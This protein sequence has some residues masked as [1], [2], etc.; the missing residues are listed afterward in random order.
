MSGFRRYKGYAR[1][2]PIAK[3]SI[4]RKRFLR[5]KKPTSKNPSNDFK[6]NYRSMG[7]S[8]FA[9]SIFLSFLMVIVSLSALTYDS[10][11]PED[12]PL[13][14]GADNIS[15]V[16]LPSDKINIAGFQDGSIYTDTP[17]T[18]SPQFACTIVDDGT[19]KCWGNLQSYRS[20][21]G[22]YGYEYSP[23]PTNGFG[24]NRTAT[25]ISSGEDHTCVIL[26]DGNISC[27][28][29]NDDGRLGTDTESHSGIPIQTSGLV[30]SNKSAVAISVGDTHSCAIIDD[31]KVV[32]WGRGGGTGGGRP[33]FG[34]GRTA[35]AI[36]TGGFNSCAILDN[37][38]VK[39]W[40]YG[41]RGQLG[42]GNSGWSYGENYPVQ[43][44]QFPGGRTAVA[45]SSGRQHSCAILDN[46]SVAC[47]GDAREGRLGNG[48]VHDHL[49]NPTL[50]SDFG[51]G[52]TAVS[53][54]A[55]YR[56]TCVVLSDGEV[57]CWGLGS[58]GRLGNGDTEQK[59][60]P[61]QTVSLNGMAVGVATGSFTS[62]ALLSNGTVYCWGSGSGGLLG[63]G[64]EYP[65]PG[66]LVPTPVANLGEG[67]YTAL[68]ERDFDNDG[69]L[70]IFEE[71]PPEIVECTGGKYGNG[72]YMCIDSP[73]GKYVP[74][75]YA[76]LA[77]DCPSGTYQNE[78]GQTS[79]KFADA[80]HFVS[81]GAGMGQTYQTP[82]LIGTYNPENGSV[83]NSDCI[84]ASTGHFVSSPGSS[85][86][87]SCLSKTYQPLDGQD[88]CLESEP[89]HFVAIPGQS[90]QTECLAGT[91]QP[92]SAQIKCIDA[93]PG[94]YVVGTAQTGQINCSSGTYNPGTK[95][96]SMDSCLAADLGHFVENESQTSQV[97]CPIGTY[98]D[99][100]GMISCKEAKSGHYV[101]SSLGPGQI[102]QQA[103]RAGT[104]NP[105]EGSTEAKSC[106][107]ADINFYVNAPA[108]IS[109]ISCPTETHQ[110]KTGQQE[111]V[112][113]ASDEGKDSE[114][115]DIS[116]VGLFA[117][118][119]MF[120]L[121]LVFIN[122][123]QEE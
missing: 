123:K 82:C 34:Q 115:S 93:E 103:C 119:S 65:H 98:Q 106:Q 100:V 6:S 43:T 88:N 79:C 94:H 95:S 77:T 32:C 68:S 60:V 28:G 18:L 78:Y 81:L 25:S 66:S 10:N 17:L 71:T 3:P 61:T 116:S 37:G 50:T 23:V 15:H 86:Q 44:T 21:N 11:Q 72:T 114:S 16:T 59:D 40:G 76:K 33:M 58:Q 110:P 52:R 117:T 101:N 56:H 55:G 118:L 9:I 67:R 96:F 36:S 51:M 12:E 75:D 7:M 46:G 27:W 2:W 111:C 4:Y 99:E 92:N 41:D 35:I 24:N 62:C 26:N 108:Q 45:I 13:F 54:S 47:W 91:Y 1:I 42:N 102:E 53:I 83:T 19:V 121:A 87:S 8:R 84:S 69:V 38:E 120:M 48:E 63:N 30:D 109:Q 90:E 64:G 97:K 22:V 105:N 107:L 31:G 57:S 5:N 113:I 49:S 85:E 20:G 112:L 104:Y 70:N 74:N 122:N 89:G 29:K 14:E 39:C 73:P 80:G